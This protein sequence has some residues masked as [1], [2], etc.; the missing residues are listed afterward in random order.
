[1]KAIWALHHHIESENRADHYDLMI[2]HGDNLAT[3]SF[4]EHPLKCKGIRGI[5]IHDH[6]RRFLEGGGKLSEGNG[7]CE[8]VESGTYEP[9]ITQEGT[10]R[11]A[12][13]TSCG[14]MEL[15]CEDKEAILR[16]M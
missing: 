5:R 7:R 13:D 3:F 16:R 1:M 15:C 14:R 12:L 6:D 2:E 8:L 4:K 10:F 9:G 11:A